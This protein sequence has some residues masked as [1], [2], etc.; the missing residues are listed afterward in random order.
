MSTVLN[1]HFTSKCFLRLGCNGDRYSL[2]IEIRSVK[3]SQVYDETYLLSS[4]SSSSISLPSCE[5]R[6]ETEGFFRRVEEI[7]G[8]T[9]IFKII[10]SKTSAIGLLNKAETMIT[11]KIIETSVAGFFQI[12]SIFLFNPITL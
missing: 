10:Y 9:K 6:G 8:R 1:P 2:T 7:D 5:G 11:R 3:S 4:L 12:T